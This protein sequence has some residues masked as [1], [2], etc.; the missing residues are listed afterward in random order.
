MRSK[1]AV[2][3]GAGKPL[4]LEEC[5]IPALCQGEVLVKNEY[6]TLCRSDISTYTGKRIEKTPT[7]LGHEIVGRV[8]ALGEGNPVLD[9]EGRPLA[10]GERVTWAIYA[11]NPDGEMARRGIPQKAPDLFKY[12]HEQLTERNTL[13][14]GLAE[15]TLLRRYTPV[16]PLAETV[17]PAAAAIIN[18]AVS[19][20]AGSL[21]LAVEKS[22]GA[23]W[24]SVGLACWVL[25]PVPCVG[26]KGLLKSLP[27]TLTGNA[28]MWH[29]ALG[30]R[31]C[32]ALAILRTNCLRLMCL[33]TTAGRL[34][35]WR[36]PWATLPSVAWRSG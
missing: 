10:I 18:C 23:K 32:I 17:P 8:V 19:T 4:Q 2:F 22:P 16:L 24:W 27:W 36:L 7:I 1:I 34:Q 15:Y 14:G 33:L 29:G 21:R 25:S 5:E 31:K 6:V 3:Y 13:H 30:L 28:W 20:V 11:S 12:G 26:K 35:R 9:L